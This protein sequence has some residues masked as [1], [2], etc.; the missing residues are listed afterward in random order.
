VCKEIKKKIGPEECSSVGE[1]LPGMCKTLGSIS[2]TIKKKPPK[3]TKT[4][5][6]TQKKEKKKRN[7]QIIDS[8]YGLISP[9]ISC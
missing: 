2:S 7:H 3:K 1:S 8:V 6:K 4:K 5:A 9:P